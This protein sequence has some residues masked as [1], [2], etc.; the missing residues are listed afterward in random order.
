[1]A[2]RS[3]GKGCQRGEGG[4]NAERLLEVADD[5]PKTRAAKAAEDFLSVVAEEDDTEDTP[6]N[7]EGLRS[8]APKSVSIWQLLLVDLERNTPASRAG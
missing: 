1:M 3:I 5:P 2:P 4:R 7:Q 8:E 6:H